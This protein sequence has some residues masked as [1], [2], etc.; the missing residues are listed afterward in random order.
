M[1]EDSRPIRPLSPY[2]AFFY[3]ER[4]THA[5]RLAD[6]YS[7]NAS[8]ADDVSIADI[9]AKRRKIDYDVRLV[10]TRIAQ[11]N[12]ER[13]MNI[14]KE[15]QKKQKNDV[16]TTPARQTLH[17]EPV[18]SDEPKT[19]SILSRSCLTGDAFSMLPLKR[20]LPIA[21]LS[22]HNSQ[23]PAN[24]EVVSMKCVRSSVQIV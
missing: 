21:P 8:I 22:V 9:S 23:T 17:C 10:L 14:L 5:K 20:S 18:P 13:R 19:P 2:E 12:K 16:V 15:M 6:S 4:N 1:H 11:E 3:L 7:D 24:S